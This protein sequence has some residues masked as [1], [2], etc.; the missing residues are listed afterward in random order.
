MI[1]GAA[2]Q[3]VKEKKITSF[4]FFLIAFYLYSFLGAP[5]RGQTGSACKGWVID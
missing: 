2:I 5:S 1:K 3:A 4:S